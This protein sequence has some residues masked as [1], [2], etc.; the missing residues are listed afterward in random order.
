MIALACFVLLDLEENR[1][2][3]A[4]VGIEEEMEGLEEI[5]NLEE[6]YRGKILI[7]SVI[8]ILSFLFIGISNSIFLY[9]LIVFQSIFMF[10]FFTFI[11]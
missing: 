5:V 4:E 1:I 11:V 10:Q 8:L 9:S 3:Q 2:E 7:I 6:S